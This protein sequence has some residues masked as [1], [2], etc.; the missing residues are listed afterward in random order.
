MFLASSSRQVQRRALHI[1]YIMPG[2]SLTIE[3]KEENGISVVYLHGD[4]DA[5]S[6]SD[7]QQ[8]VEPLCL[9]PQPKIL[10]ECTSLDYVNSTGYGVLFTLDRT[11]RQNGGAIT[12]CCVRSKILKVAKV[13]GLES[14]LT[15]FPTKEEAMASMK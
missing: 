5:A 11:C 2:P 6:I 9:Q 10:L 4:I 14:L 8:V 15:I 1:M 12:L 7:F 3:V 13:L